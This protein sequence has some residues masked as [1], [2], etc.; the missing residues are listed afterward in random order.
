M[1]RR[2]AV[3]FSAVLLLSVL[4]PQREARSQFASPGKLSAP[5][6]DLEGLLK[7]TRC[8]DLKKPGAS[9]AKC[10]ECHNPLQ[11]RLAQQKGYHATVSER[12][13][14][15]CHAEHRGREMTIVDLDTTNFDHALT[16]FELTAKHGEVPCRDCHSPDFVTA[17]DVRAFKQKHGSLDRTLLGLGTE[18]STCHEQD[19][20]HIDQFTGRRCEECHSEA[21]WKNAERFDHTQTRYRLTGRHR[22]A[23]CSKCHK[24]TRTRQGKL[25]VRFAPLEF[26]TC[27]SCHKDEHGGKL[28][29]P[30]TRCHST[31]GWHRVRRTTVEDDF[32]HSNTKFALVGKHEEVECDGCHVEKDTRRQ[33]LRITVRPSTRNFAYPHPVAEVCTSCH[34]DYHRNAFAA[35][36]GGTACDN[37][38][39]ETGWTP[40]Q[41][42]VARHNRD[43]KF[44]LEGA[45]VATPCL[46]CHET[47][48][49]GE[50]ATQFRIT[51]VDCQSCHKDDDPHQSQFVE[52]ACEDCHDT[53][54]FKIEEFDHASTRYR[55]DGAHEDVPCGSCHLR[56]VGAGG[57]MFTRYKPL[58]IR[59]QDCHTGK[60]NRD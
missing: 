15:S 21:S 8:H 27:E 12:T 42:D 40:G 49:E 52:S 44:S 26:N 55:L 46:E 39:D 28:E 10:L 23:E 59:C 45:H 37:C 25:M 57:S 43:A 41:Y 11:A 35:A 60:G 7:C 17:A 33:R 51:Q 18:C 48:A 4:V 38:H 5:H 53:R 22:R 34:L 14:G 13:C 29:G 16:G 30:C 2:R 19:D 31:S 24:A 54:A 3:V 9:E 32:D 20:P 36:P 56:E 47:P 58:G 6:E 50:E 1:T